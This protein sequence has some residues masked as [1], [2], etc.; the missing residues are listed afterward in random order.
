MTT[1]PPMTS[2]QRIALL[3]GTLREMLR[4]DRAAIAAESD[5]TERSMAIETALDGRLRRDWQL[6]RERARRLLGA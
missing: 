5:P 6:L 4:I 1:P 2:D 3:E